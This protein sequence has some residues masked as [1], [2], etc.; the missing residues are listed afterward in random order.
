[1]K[2]LPCSAFM[3]AALAQQHMTVALPCSAK[4]FCF[5]LL[6]VMLRISSVPGQ[7]LDD[8]M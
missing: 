6:C 2:H 4:P 3:L 5:L 1:M 8:S 7:M